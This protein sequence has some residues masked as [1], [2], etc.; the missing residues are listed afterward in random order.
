MKPLLCIFCFILLLPFSRGEEPP[1]SPRN[2]SGKVTVE[3]KMENNEDGIY[4][5]FTTKNGLRKDLAL[6]LSEVP[7]LMTFQ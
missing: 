6:V 3:A 2:E 7:G 4:I 1:V 5:R